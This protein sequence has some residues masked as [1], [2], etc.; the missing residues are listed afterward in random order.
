MPPGV[1]EE[2]GGDDAH[3]AAGHAA[4]MAQGTV[5]KTPQ[6]RSPIQAR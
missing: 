6:F 2:P 5:E 4:E 3:G 1:P